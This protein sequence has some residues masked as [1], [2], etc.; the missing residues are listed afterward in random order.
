MKSRRIIVCLCAVLTVSAI[1]VLAKG[2]S[3][4]I[5]AIVD[6]VEFEPN[7]ESPERVRIWGVF[8]VP[9]PMSSGQYR[10]PQRGY[11]YFRMV[12]GLERVAEQEWHEL[13][14]VAGTGQGIGFAQYW[15]PNS[16]DPN[17]NPHHSL[18]VEVHDDGYAVSPE[19]YPLRHQRGIVWTGDGA[20][21]D[22]ERI[23]AQ[24]QRAARRD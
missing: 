17:G 4:G 21:P 18:T 1:H 24:L 11:V 22:F 19:V 20:D 5:Y 6:K 23:M 13:K 15:V 12:P 2:G 14:A 8:I 9:V 7:E 3:I 10:A 16:A